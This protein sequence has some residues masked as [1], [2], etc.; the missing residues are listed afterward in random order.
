MH[1]S[2]VTSQVCNPRKT[3]IF[4][5]KGLMWQIFIHTWV[6]SFHL[7]RASFNPKSYFTKKPNQISKENF[8][9][10]VLRYVYTIFSLY[11]LRLCRKF[12]G[13]S[14]IGY[15]RKRVGNLWFCDFFFNIFD[16]ALSHLSCLCLCWPHVA[17][18]TCI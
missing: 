5:F 3:R 14:W 9:K 10:Y 15:F 1:F 6:A 2:W 17:I 13:F 8:F 18:L 11:F 16:W 7:P 12:L 4:N